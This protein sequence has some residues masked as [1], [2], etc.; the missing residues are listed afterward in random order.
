M[1]GD[2]LKRKRLKADRRLTGKRNDKPWLL[3]TGAPF[4]KSRKVDLSLLQNVCVYSSGAPMV[5]I[6]FRSQY[7]HCMQPSLDLSGRLTA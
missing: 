6:I 4:W 1:R 3:E 2:V 5:G 7:Y